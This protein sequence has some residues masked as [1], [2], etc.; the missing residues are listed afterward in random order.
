L[1]RLGH[2]ETH[3]GNRMAE[4]L[5]IILGAVDLEYYVVDTLDPRLVPCHSSARHR[6]DTRRV[7]GFSTGAGYVSIGCARGQ[8]MDFSDGS[9]R[10]RGCWHPKPM[11]L[12][13]SSFGEKNRN[14]DWATSCPLVR[15]SSFDGCLRHDRALHAHRSNFH[16][17]SL[18]SRDILLTHT[19]YPSV[20]E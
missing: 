17:G 2:V 3:S 8:R 7:T 19:R 11:R 13:S 5:A 12:R 16:F 6:T 1:I 18:R 14:H 4:D 20:A 9:V 10:T 15:R